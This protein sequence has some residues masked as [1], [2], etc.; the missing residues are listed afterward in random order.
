MELEAIYGHLYLAGGTRQTGDPPGVAVRS[1]PDRSARGRSRDTLFLHVTLTSREQAPA[2]LYQEIVDTLSDTFFGGVGSVTAAL[3]QAIRA[4]NEYLMRYNTRVE[5]VRKQQAGV[6]CAVLREEEVFIAQAGSTL[7]IMGHEG[8]LERLPPRASGQITPL[9]VGYGVDTRFYHSWVHPG[10]VILLSNPDFGIHDVEEIG[11]AIIY[12][13]VTAGIANLAQLASR[14]ETARLLVVEFCAAMEAVVQQPSL[15]KAARI[16]PSAPATAR[17]PADLTIPERLPVPS[18]EVDVKEEARKAASGLAIGLA[19]LTEGIGK[20][21]ER[22]FGGPPAAR[23]AVRKD[24]G[25]PPATL[26]LLAILIPVLVALI[27]VTVYLQRGRTAQFQELLQQMERESQLAL[28]MESEAQARPHWERIQLLSEDAI[29]LRPSHEIVLAFR[30]Q[31]QGKLD[32]LDEVTRLVVR[33]LVGYEGVGD[34]NAVVLQGMSVYVLDS[35]HDQVYKHLLQNDTEVAEGVKAESI[36]FKTQAV[37]QAV[38]GELVD[39]IW[40]PSSGEIDADAIV[41][42]D[43]GGWLVRYNPFE[44]EVSSTQLQLPS[45]WAKPVAIAAYGDALYVLDTGAPQIWRFGSEDDQFPTS[46]TTYR[47]D[48]ASNVDLSRMTDMTIDRDGN[49]YLLAVDGTIHKFFDGE[50]K[51]FT[52]TGLPAPLAAPNAIF[53][54]L[55]GL[56][57][58]FYIADPGSGRIIRTT[59][60]GLFLAQYRAAGAEMPDPFASLRSIYIQEVPA[61]AVY[62]T[63]G[64][65]LIVATL[66]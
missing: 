8:Q 47:F 42:L 58:F 62:A 18:P 45:R 56:N 64:E 63:S 38:V 65:S 24:Q 37:G 15:E 10:D 59:Q 40:F 22:L 9:G 20:M 43:A 23:Q 11:R 61:L 53:C 14:E 35:G 52:L 13:G 50:R 21:I 33:S 25:P 29:K 7:A 55:T 46:P 2:S 44:G 39:L 54:S 31:A 16:A 57:P 19:R 32:L 28:A 6:T 5:G 3:R 41:V 66:E 12:E 34:P 26:A 30:Q 51:P 27:A 60:Q 17:T 36:V 48:A 1:W 49:L 4:A